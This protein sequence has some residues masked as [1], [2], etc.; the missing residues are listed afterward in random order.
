MLDQ[1]HRKSLVDQRA[2]M[3]GDIARTMLDEYGNDRSSR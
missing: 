2:Q 3:S 1:Q